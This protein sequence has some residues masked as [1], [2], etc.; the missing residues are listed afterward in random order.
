M[1]HLVIKM[2]HCVIALADDCMTVQLHAC[3]TRLESYLSLGVSVVYFVM[4]TNSY[5][6]K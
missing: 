5:V 3:V 2:H 6:I 1:I 4:Y